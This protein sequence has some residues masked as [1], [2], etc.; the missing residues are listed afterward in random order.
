MVVAGWADGYRNNTFR[1]VA[2]LR[3]AG[4][5][6]R[7]LAGPWAHADPAHGIPGPRIDLTVESVAWW[8]RWLRGRQETEHVDHVDLFVRTSTRP[9]PDLEEHDGWWVRDTWPSRATRWRKTV[10]TGSRALDVEPDVGTAAWI[11]CAGHLPWGLSDDQREDDARSLTWEW[12]ADRA[13][14]VGQP[15]VRL[16][17]SASAPSAS[18]SVKLCDVFSDGTS[19]LVSR[20]SLDLAF[21][22]GLHAP[23]VPAPLEPGTEYDVVVDLDACA[24]AFAPGQRMR[25]SVA[26]ADWPN[27]AAPPAP[28]TMTVHE[29]ALRLPTWSGSEQEPPVFTPGA[30]AS[31]EDPSDVLWT[32]SRD[33]LRRTTTCAVRHGDAYDVP[34]D[35]RAT[36]SYAGAVTVDRRTFAQSATAECTFTLC[37][38]TNEVSV[39]ST[40]DVRVTDRG[41]DVRIAA[42]AL[43]DGKQV[44]H[45]TWHEDLPR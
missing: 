31:A 21:R 20:G 1:T 2:A 22:D 45:R 32:V 12:D 5:P 41:Y 8:D 42:E 23:A 6:H 36:E 28:V 17:V 25:L 15:Q 26:G 4:V 9:A 30:A 44:A 29:V 43:S 7:L 39:T 3:R 37:W 33:V 34:Y 35:G 18:L 11:D 38:P 13:V 14:V 10:L 16:R 27:T 19:A 40:L 24:Y